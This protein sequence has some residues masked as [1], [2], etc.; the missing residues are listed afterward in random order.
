MSLGQTDNGS[1]ETHKENG[2]LARVQQTQSLVFTGGEDPGAIPVPAGAVYHVRV[3]IN[4]H[5]CLPTSHIPKD[6]DVVTACKVNDNKS[7]SL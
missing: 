3:H 4:P 2:A 1:G 7:T 5:R 6:N